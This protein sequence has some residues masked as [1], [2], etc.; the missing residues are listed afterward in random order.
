MNRLR[1]E[2][3]AKGLL[4]FEADGRDPRNVRLGRLDH[5]CERLTPGK[6]APKQARPS[7][8][9]ILKIKEKKLRH[10]GGV[11]QLLG[12]SRVGRV[13]GGVRSRLP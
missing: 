5:H 13:C 9:A 3:D 12:A 11:L 7:S 1:G 4:R 2:L 6:D 10:T 8:K